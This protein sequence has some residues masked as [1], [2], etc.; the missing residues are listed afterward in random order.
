[1][2]KQKDSKSQNGEGMWASRKL[3]M[4]VDVSIS[5]GPMRSMKYET[6]RE[7]SV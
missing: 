2:D 6:K 5:I 4:S 7:R 1:V 3:G